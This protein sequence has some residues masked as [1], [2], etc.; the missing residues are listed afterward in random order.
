MKIIENILTKNDCY[1][2]GRQT[3]VKGLMLHSVGCSQPNASVF[4]N[5]WN[6]PN[7]EVCVHAFIDGNT[8]DVYQTL[9]WYWRGWH[10]GGSG[11]N[12]HIGIEMCEPATIA[13]TGGAS[14]TDKNP[15]NT[16]ATILRTYQ[17]AVSLFAQLCKEYKLNPLADGVIVSH[18]EGYKRGIASNHADVEHIWKT[19]G[20][21]MDLFRQEVKG[22]QSDVQGVLY[23]V[24]LGA[25][26]NRINADRFLTEIKGKGYDAFVTYLDG[27]YK[28]QVGAYS[29]S[30]NADAMVS[31]LKK[32]GYS[33]FVTKSVSTKSIDE[34]AREV[35]AGKWGNGQDRRDRLT[36]DGYD[37]D[38][39]QSRI[40]VILACN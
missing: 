34:I 6:R 4:L 38:A 30:K 37:Y 24:Q 20:L 29:V 19:F 9:P 7:Y 39:I 32:E 17:S 3:T 2:K 22:T 31:K 15:E 18:S 28:V 14:W 5:S 11:N 10:C 40:N 12:T 16:R 33:A 23:R 13:Y 25:F 35:I 8:G 1:T 21:S 26:T 27:F 36:A